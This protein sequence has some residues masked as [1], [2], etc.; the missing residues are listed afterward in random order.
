MLNLL[1]KRYDPKAFRI[2]IDKYL[3]YFFYYY[4]MSSVTITE[5]ELE[6]IK[7]NAEKLIKDIA[8]LTDQD[9][10]AFERMKDIKNNPEMFTSEKEL[11]DF[12]KKRGVK[13][14]PVD[15]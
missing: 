14:D 5:K 11:N 1:S 13:L 6:K 2:R 12:L 4:I 9:R 15:N 10:I 3:N 7:N 8:K